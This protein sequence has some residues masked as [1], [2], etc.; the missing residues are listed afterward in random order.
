MN[1]STPGISWSYVTDQWAQVLRKCH[2]GL[3]LDAAEC[4]GL[5]REIDL[6]LKVIRMFSPDHLEQRN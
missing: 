6:A 4:E 2:S 3:T 5:A 1:E